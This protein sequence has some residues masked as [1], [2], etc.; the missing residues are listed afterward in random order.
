MC[1]F[2]VPTCQMKCCNRETLGLIR[3]LTIARQRTWREDLTRTSRSTKRACQ[4]LC[5]Q[6]LRKQIRN[7]DKRGSNPDLNPR[8]S[9][10]PGRPVERTSG[11]NVNVKVKN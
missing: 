1:L 11:K 3:K 2:R 8:S 10:L 4:R 5:G 6:L 9:A 7:A